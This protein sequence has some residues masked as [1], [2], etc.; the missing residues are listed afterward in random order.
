MYDEE[1]DAI[2]GVSA[3]QNGRA[4]SEA[5][6][7][8]ELV[9]GDGIDSAAAYQEAFN[10]SKRRNLKSGHYKHSKSSGKM[11]RRRWKRHLQV[12]GRHLE[13]KN[14]LANGKH[15]Y[16]KFYYAPQK[17]TYYNKYWDATS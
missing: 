4:N 7:P 6:K 15:G 16:G 17:I 10:L 5:I 12:E 13:A 2:D 11:S 8:Q 1:V 14:P 3:D 9:L